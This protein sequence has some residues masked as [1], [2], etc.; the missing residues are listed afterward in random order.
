MKLFIDYGQKFD[1]SKDAGLWLF[2]HKNCVVA[3]CALFSYIISVAVILSQGLMKG[4]GNENTHEFEFH[5]LFPVYNYNY[6]SFQN[7]ILPYWVVFQY[8][9]IISLFYILL[10][11]IIIYYILFLSANS[12]LLYN[13]I[14]SKHESRQRDNT[15]TL[16]LD[17]KT[18][19]TWNQ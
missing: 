11:Y 5:W 2:C 16:S 12:W 15:V 13:R 8:A 9:V 4:H 17:N 18:Y 19:I 10:I 1:S 7:S 3:Q 6:W 14:T